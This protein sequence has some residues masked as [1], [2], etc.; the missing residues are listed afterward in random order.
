MVLN[1]L[2]LNA[3]EHG[4]TGEQ[5]GRIEIV[6]HDLGNSVSMEILNNGRSLPP[7]FDLAQTK[8][9]GLQ[10]VR[11]LVTDDLKGKLIIEPMPS[12]APEA[13]ASR[14]ASAAAAMPPTCYGTR[15]VVTFPKRPLNVD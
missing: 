3:V 7:D 10:I 1:E 9:L 2:V 13:D 14:A 15:A 11:T 5:D 4:I 6:L 12:A 8:S